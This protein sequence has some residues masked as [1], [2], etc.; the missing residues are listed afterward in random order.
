MLT[1]LDLFLWAS[2]VVGH[3]LL[4]AVLLAR[5]R[6]RQFPW[7]T[8]L[9][10]ANVGRS[11][12][13]YL[14][15]SHGN[16][17]IYRIA[18][19]D[20]ALLVDG[21]LQLAVV[22]ELAR[23]VFRPLGYWAPDVRRAFLFLV[24]AS[25]IVAAALAWLAAPRALSWRDNLAVKGSFFSSALLGELLIGMIALSATVG[26]PWKTHVARIAQGLG[27][28]SLLDMLIEGAHSLYGANYETEVDIG[29][30]HT[31]MMLYLG[32]LLY[33]I[34]TLWQDAPEPRA[35]SDEA[36]KHLRSLQTR[37]AYDLWTLRS[38]R[39]P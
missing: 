26:L 9:I 12:L 2:G 16:P 6:C 3:A 18:Y 23:R 35:L 28:F 19:W 14:L 30:S 1:H 37:L 10:G 5:G 32:C 4:F 11:L 27:L 34:V 8:A 7:F 38:W 17:E 39:R 21:F 13:L 24:G 15:S 25:V 31:R 33:W 29:L 20:L 22:L 36:K